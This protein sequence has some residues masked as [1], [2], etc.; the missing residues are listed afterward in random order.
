MD[1][2]NVI[3][4]YSTK[5]LYVDVVIHFRRMCDKYPN[6]LKHNESTIMDQVKEENVCA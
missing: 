5:E 6:L 1:A 3:I 2:W 4:N